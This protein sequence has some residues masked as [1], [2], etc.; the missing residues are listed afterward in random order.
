MIRSRP[1]EQGDRL[2]RDEF[3]RR[4]EAMPPGV[5]AELINGVVYMPIPCPSRCARRAPP[6]SRD[7]VGS[8][9]SRH[10]WSSRGR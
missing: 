2:T 8:L 5:K 6:E 7:V 9:Q 4:Y 10:P 1:L 3:E